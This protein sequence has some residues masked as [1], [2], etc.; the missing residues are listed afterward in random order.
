MAIIRGTADWTAQLEAGWDAARPVGS[1]EDELY[2]AHGA[3]LYTRYEWTGEV[4]AVVFA[5]KQALGRY[6]RKLTAE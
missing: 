2:Y 4:D 5:T 1:T 3:I 6:V